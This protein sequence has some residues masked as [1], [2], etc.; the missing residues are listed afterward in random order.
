MDNV[1][2]LVDDAA[3]DKARKVSFTP[4]AA[5]TL[6]RIIKSTLHDAVRQ[7]NAAPVIPHTDMV[8]RM[9]ARLLYASNYGP[10]AMELA[11]SL[12]TSLFFTTD[13]ADLTVDRADILE[14][15]LHP[16][17]P[18]VHEVSLLVLKWWFASFYANTAATATIPPGPNGVNII[19]GSMVLNLVIPE[20]APCA[21]VNMDHL[22]D[23]AKMRL[24]CLVTAI[25]PPSGGPEP[26]F[27]RAHDLT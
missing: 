16:D 5:E 17:A 12:G 26:P 23:D 19:F 8:C 15:V 1:L 3:Y 27:H 21:N 18:G 20:G 13:L 7:P 10:V 9:G 6:A 14:A 22:E 25:P 24:L 11:R 4:Q 2:R